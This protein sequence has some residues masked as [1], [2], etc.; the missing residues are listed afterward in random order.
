MPSPAA[1]SFSFLFPLFGPGSCL[2]A[3]SSLLTSEPQQGVLGLNAGFYHGK[4][5]AS[6]AGGG[7]IVDGSALP[8]TTLNEIY[9]IRAMKS[10]ERPRRRKDTP[11]LR[12]TMTFPGALVIR[13]V[14]A[15]DR[16]VQASFVRVQVFRHSPFTS[17]VTLVV[18]VF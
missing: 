9:Y 16:R 18:L 2:L 5:I 17:A 7:F 15:V 8:R 12:E 3:A 11:R 10:P 4:L 13:A 6:F 1:R 14:T